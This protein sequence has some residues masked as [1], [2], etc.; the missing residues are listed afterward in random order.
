MDFDPAKT[1]MLVASYPDD[2]HTPELA[3]WAAHIGLDLP[4]QFGTYCEQGITVAYNKAVI[5]ALQSKYETFI[6]ADR[7]VRP[8]F[9]ADP[10]LTLDADIACCVY[11]VCEPDAWAKPE[12]FHT[13]LWRVRRDVLASLDRPWFRT[14]YSPDGTV[15]AKCCCTYF[16][17]KAIAAGFTVAHAGWADHKPWQRPHA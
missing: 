13:G 12:A 7:D 17:D 11:P 2:M 14:E 15:E 9:A 16:R 5:T 1:L 8:S 6:F 10:F 3:R 4:S